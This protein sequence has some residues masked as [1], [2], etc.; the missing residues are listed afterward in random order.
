MP[1][2]TGKIV[3]SVE[4]SE[5]FL[6]DWRKTIGELIVEN[7]YEV[8]DSILAVYGM[9]GRYS[10]SHESGRAYLA[11]GMEVKRHA[12]VPMAAQWVIDIPKIDGH[13]LIQADIRESA[14]VAHIYGQNIVAGESLTSIGLDNKAW[15]H[16]PA[17]LKTS[18]DNEL[19]NDLNR[20]FIHTSP[21]Q[22][23]DDKKPGLGLYIF[24]QWF[25][26]HDTWAEQ[27]R[28]WTDYLARSS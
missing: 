11:D 8:E 25:D 6:W 27:A 20:F 15:S 16:H 17:N 1:V 5:R 7:S 21:H 24:G 19:A 2:L 18:V 14:S 13:P 23:V 26:R 22:P 28:C 10:E 4:A 3:D 12:A 9:K